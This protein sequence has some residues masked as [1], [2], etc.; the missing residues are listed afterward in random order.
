LLFADAGELGLQRRLLLGQA[1]VAQ[2]AETQQSGARRGQKKYQRRQAVQSAGSKAPAAEAATGL[3]QKYQAD[4]RT[5]GGD[6]G[7]DHGR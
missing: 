6:S 2:E 7:D 3:K 4:Q 1:L 5:Q